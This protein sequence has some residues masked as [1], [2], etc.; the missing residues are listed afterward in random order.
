MPDHVE[1]RFRAVEST[2]LVEATIQRWVSRLDDVC[3]RMRSCSVVVEQPSVGFRRPKFA[4]SVEVV[5]D[6]AKTQCLA[7]HSDVYIA[8]AD[9]FRATVRQMR[10]QEVVRQNPHA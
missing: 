1:I 4:V 10:D 3:D 6:D 8:V 2:P 9:A 7:T 5:I